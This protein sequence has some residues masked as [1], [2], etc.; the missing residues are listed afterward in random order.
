MN[1]MLK[2]YL[3]TKGKHHTDINKFFCEIMNETKGNI[4]NELE[5]EGFK[6][7]REL[8]RFLIQNQLEQIKKELR[9]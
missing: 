3:E 4:L 8:N 2:I 6:D 5:K 1:E 7:F 9:I